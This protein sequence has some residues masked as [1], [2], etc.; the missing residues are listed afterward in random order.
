M[1]LVRKEEGVETAAESLITRHTIAESQKQRVR[2][3]VA[4]DTTTNQQVS[5]AVLEKLERMSRPTG[6]M[7]W[8]R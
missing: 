3:L 4:D 1:T 5:L 7:R 8:P 2:I 6:W